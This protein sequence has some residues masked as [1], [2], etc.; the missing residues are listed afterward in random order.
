[1][2]CHSRYC[3]RRLHTSNMT[4]R[5]WCSPRSLG[6]GSLSGFSTAK[7]TLSPL[8]LSHCPLWKEVTA[9][10]LEGWRG[11]LHLLRLLAPTYIN[12]LKFFC[13]VDLSILPNIFTYS[14]IYLYQYGLKD[15]YFIPWCYN[16]LLICLLCCPNCFSF[17]HW[18]LLTLI[19]FGYFFVIPLSY[20]NLV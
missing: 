19:F 9:W 18:E 2:K 5:C 20:L 8:P 15:F 3:K 10:P 14:D 1:M 13:S 4:Y 12:Y 17:D 7:S 16:S 11:R 6:W